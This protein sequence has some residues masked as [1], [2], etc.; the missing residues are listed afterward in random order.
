MKGGDV[1]GRKDIKSSAIKE[2]YSKCGN[3]CA[4]IGCTNK[5]FS[6]DE[7]GRN[8]ISNICHIEGYN[9]KS[10]RYNAN[11]SE[12]K[13]NDVSNLILLCTIHH[14]YID[15]N[16]DIYSVDFLKS[17]KESHEKKIDCL[18]YK[19]ILNAPI[20]NFD[21]IG[22]DSLIEYI[23]SN[24]DYNL[25][26]KYLNKLFK[27][28]SSQ[29]PVTLEI[30]YKIIEYYYEN[31]N[32]NMECICNETGLS[33]IEFSSQLRLLVQNDFIDETYY[34]N[35]MRSFIESDEDNIEIVSENYPYKMYNGIWQL[36]ERGYI[37]FKILKY[38]DNCQYFYDLLVNLN[39]K[40]IDS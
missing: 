34:D 28:I 27:K 18:L 3:T 24:P 7:N 11:L 12:V 31:S 17:L 21:N 38:I 6:D 8:H 9:E 26:K 33:D 19:K 2:L 5:L 39:L 4:F 40:Y 10:A 35:S 36:K 15:Q 29:K 20:I 37:L 14:G 22:C 1:L 25:D 32:L 30:L 23:N 16:E 13:A